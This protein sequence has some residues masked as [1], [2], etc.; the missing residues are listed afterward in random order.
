MCEYKKTVKIRV[1]GYELKPRCEVVG[2]VDQHCSVIGFVGRGE[3]ECMA[4]FSFA[5]KRFMFAAL[6]ASIKI[7]IR[8]KPICSYLNLL[9]MPKI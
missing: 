9:H 8:Q 2:G 7:F 6:Q 5:L 3:H 1:G 4:F